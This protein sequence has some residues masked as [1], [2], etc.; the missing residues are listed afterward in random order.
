MQERL[1]RSNPAPHI[2]FFFFAFFDIPWNITH[3]YTNIWNLWYNYLVERVN[4]ETTKNS[5]SAVT[6]FLDILILR[7]HNF[8]FHV[9]P[10]LI[11]V[12]NAFSVAISL[13]LP[14]LEF[15]SVGG[16]KDSLTA[17]PAKEYDQHLKKG[18]RRYG[19]KLH[20]EVRFQFWSS[21]KYRDHPFIAITPR[22]ILALHSYMVSSIPI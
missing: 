6:A 18:S 21:R 22:F 7:F 2:L 19:I 14:F 11:F 17:S 1:G 13:S 10:C 20:P 3:N 4:H 9:C 16:A 8:S 5:K 15:T 12:A